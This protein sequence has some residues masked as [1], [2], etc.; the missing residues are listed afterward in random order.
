VMMWGASAKL[1]AEFSN[2]E[3][4]KEKYNNNKKKTTTWKHGNP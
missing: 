3:V 1:T 4:K 2:E